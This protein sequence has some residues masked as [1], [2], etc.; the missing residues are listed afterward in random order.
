MLYSF[1]DSIQAPSKLEDGN[2]AYCRFTSNNFA[3]KG[4]MSSGGTSCG[5]GHYDCW[6]LDSEKLPSGTYSR[7]MTPYYYD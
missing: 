7:A 4:N 2:V 5:Y 3:N 6:D 1:K